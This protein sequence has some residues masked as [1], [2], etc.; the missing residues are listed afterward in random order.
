M[1]TRILAVILTLLFC[2]TP[3]LAAEAPG[4]TEAGYRLPNGWK[5][6]PI[7]TPVPVNDLVTNLLPSP[8]GKFML[9]LS[10][11][12]NPHQLTLIS[13]AT[14]E[15]AQVI[16]LP[17]TFMGLAWS[18]DGA[19]LFVSGGNNRAD[20]GIRAPVY[21]FN[22]DGA[23]LSEKPVRE[24][25]ETIEPENIYWCALVHHPS[26]PILYAANRTA[27]NVVVFDTVTGNIVTRVSTG[28]NP[29]DLVLS[30]DGTKLYCSNWASDSV[31]VIDTATN[32]VT[33][34]IEVGNSPNDMI[35]GKDGQLFVCCS[36]DN[37]VIVI[38]TAKG[39]AVG[40]IVTSL[41]DRAP[42][43][44]TP[45]ALALDPEQ[46]TLYIANADNNNVCVVDVEDPAEHTVLGFLPAGWYPSALGMSLDGKQLY[47]GNA[48]GTAT[49]ANIRG[50]HS[51]LPD[52]P[53][54]KGTTKST[55]KG[56][57]NIV[58]VEDYKARLRELTKQAYANCPYSDDLLAKAKARTGEASVVPETV[59]V[60]SAIK[61]VIY[62]IK[63][64][65]TYDQVLG[66]L[67]QGNGDP[68]ICIFGR[69][70][71]PNQ[72]ALAEQFVLLDNIY[73]DAEVSSDGHQWSNAAYATD[74]VEKQ[75]PAAYSGLSGAPYTEASV[76]DSGYLWDL[77][78][79]KGLTYRSYGEFAQR[80]SE[81][82]AMSGRMPGLA[83]HVAPNY[84]NWGARDTENAAEFIKEFDAYEANFDSTDPEKRLPNYIV[85]GLP[86]D[87]TVGSSPGKPTINA[88]VGS[89]DL[90]LGLI[91]ERVSH[92]KYWPETAIFVIE[93]DA[94]DGSDHVDARRTTGYVFSPYVRRG[95]VDSTFY[96]TSSMLRT[97]EL[98]LGLPPMSQYDASANPMYRT[99]TDKADNTPFTHLEPTTDLS[100]INEVT[101]WGAKESSEM[102][103]SDYDR[104]PMAQF[105]EIIWKNAK[106]PDSKMPLP[107]HRFVA[108]SLAD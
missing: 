101:A 66:D 56:S 106:G 24:F 59:G 5:I 39:R 60:G 34:T 100:A 61:H 72:H 94:Q 31:S 97:I 98:L 20:E 102:D 87:H 13:T 88:A 21:L 64:N 4:P 37:T 89:N 58:S 71:T 53:E 69:E 10:S 103:F 52:G 45:N 96:T 7:G 8:D 26:L 17:T 54:G 86:E 18:P 35:L 55:M 27:G 25:V 15:P 48:K 11:G 33:A 12:Y 63:E 40:T 108:A 6:T 74:F 76:P 93:D 90:G 28:I 23:R 2:S 30:P 49:A 42:E 68:R 3:L 19:T 80:V 43:G 32:A 38:D 78:K 22:Y 83:G 92:S 73:C 16:D 46:E 91:V 67:P 84:L 77:C 99:F 1:P 65:R 62:I 70:I 41:H 29:Y 57:V 81:G 14:G 47:I 44:S 9:A 95:T 75:W 79:R 105:N 36:N 50:P 107:V 82:E 85:M 51:P 104:M